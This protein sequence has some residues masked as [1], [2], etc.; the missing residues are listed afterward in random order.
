MC[1]WTASWLRQHNTC[2]TCRAQ[3]C[4]PP[5]STSDTRATTFATPR[6]DAAPPPPLPPP[7]APATGAVLLP[8]APSAAVPPPPT[9]PP[10]TADELGVPM[11]SFFVEPQQVGVSAEVP[12]QPPALADQVSAS[13]SAEPSAMADANTTSASSSASQAVRSEGMRFISPLL[14]WFGGLGDN[15]LRLPEVASAAA[16]SEDG[17]RVEDVN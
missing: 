17:M 4:D 11:P 16:A 14:P 10:P 3:P 2:P 9:P 5:P 15:L 1:L 13:A 8:S 7:P 12:V 6:A